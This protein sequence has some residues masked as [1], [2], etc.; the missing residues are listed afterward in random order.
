M[1]DDEENTK[2][3][4]CMYLWKAPGGVF[5]LELACPSTAK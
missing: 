3:V 1:R 5:R 2:L 4:A